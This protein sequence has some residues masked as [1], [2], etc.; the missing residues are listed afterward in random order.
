[1]TMLINHAAQVVRVARAARAAKVNKRA[2]E[3]T[4]VAGVKAAKVKKQANEAKAVKL[5]S[6]LHES[7]IQERPRRLR[8]TA[9]LRHHQLQMHL[10][11]FLQ[12]PSFQAA[13][14]LTPTTLSK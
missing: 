10:R 4:K 11:L 7:Q 9:K 3:V 1:M 14:S 8:C 6:H 12:L 5:K 13:Y 2:E